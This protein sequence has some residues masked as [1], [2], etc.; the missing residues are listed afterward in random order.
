MENGLTQSRYP[1]RQTQV[2]PPFSLIWVLMLHDQLYYDRVPLDDQMVHRAGGVVRAYERLFE[3][4]EIQQFW[5]FA[6]WVPA[7]KWGEPPGGS[8]STT[9]RLFHLLARLAHLDLLAAQGHPVKDRRR[10]LKSEFLT[11]YLDDEGFVTHVEDIEG[12]PS[13]HA[14]ALYRIAAEQLGLPVSPWPTR[15][16]EAE[17]AARC[18]YYFDF[19]KLEAIQPDDYLAWM[20]PWEEMLALGLTTFA[21]NPEPTRSDCH[22]WSAHPVIGFFRHVAGIRSG[23]PGWRDVTVRPRPG[24]LRK[25]EA[26]VDHMDGEIVVAYEDGRLKVESPVPVEI[27]WREQTAKLEAGTHSV[28]A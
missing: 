12:G 24:S 25:F 7:W 20:K 13:E 21:E 4:T 28:N 26:R 22:A 3:P 16:L 5:N 27:I 19:Y 18:T 17:E 23:S 11:H 2:I 10:A 1:S 6:D 9:H 14:E 15:R 8:S